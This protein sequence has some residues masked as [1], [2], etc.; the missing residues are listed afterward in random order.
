[1]RTGIV[2]FLFLT[3]FLNVKSASCQGYAIISDSKHLAIVNENG[4]VRYSSEAAHNNYL[5]TIRQRLDDININVSS[6]VLVQDIIHRSLSEVNAALRSGL[7]LRQIAQ[8]STEIILEC[9]QM[10]Q[11]AKESPHLLL[12]AEEVAG[13]MKNRGV[14]L[15]A[16][17]SDFI[18]KEGQNVLMD[19]EKRDALL[20]KIVLELKVMRALTYSMHRSMDRAKMVG[21]L[22][23]L[24]PYQN[25]IN[26]DVRLVDDI[27]YKI[28]IIKE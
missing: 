3:I 15:I 10:L 1:M 17:V 5:S 27:I 21:V 18:L 8:I 28:K 24:N 11:V 23:S 20:R 13:L 26:R 22:K 6:V 25:F 2:V 12:F 14:D 7:A 4:A 9:E 19:Y 16:E